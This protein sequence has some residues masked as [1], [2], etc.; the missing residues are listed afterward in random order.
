M[1]KPKIIRPEK[2]NYADPIYRPPPKPA[3]L[4]THIYPRE[5]E[6]LDTH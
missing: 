1:S 2:I 5:T 4:H 6:N 3:E